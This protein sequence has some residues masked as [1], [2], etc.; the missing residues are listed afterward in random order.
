MV[1]MAQVEPAIQ[2]IAKTLTRGSIRPEYRN[3]DKQAFERWIDG[4]GSFK[5]RIRK[6]SPLYK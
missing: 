3:A 5:E 1:L 2:S 4:K 6:G